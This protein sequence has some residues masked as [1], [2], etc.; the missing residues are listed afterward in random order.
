VIVALSICTIA[1][2]V[3][4]KKPSNYSQESQWKFGHEDKT[5]SPQIPE[6]FGMPSAT[7]IATPDIKG[8][9]GVLL[10]EAEPVINLDE[11]KI[12]F[13]SPSVISGLEIVGVFP[14]SAAAN[15]GLLVGDKILAVD[16]ELISKTTLHSL[17][18]QFSRQ[19]AARPIG[20]KICLHILRNQKMRKIFVPV[21]PRPKTEA[22]KKIHP[23]LRRDRAI[24]SESFLYRVLKD[25]NLL[26]DYYRTAWEIL[27]KATDVISY[28]IDSKKLNQFRLE[29][30][31]Y[32]LNNPMDLP[33]IAEKMVTSLENQ[34][35]HKYSSFSGLINEAMEGLDMD[36]FKIESKKGTVLTVSEI[37]DLMLKAL[38]EASKVRTEALSKLSANDI[39]KLYHSIS[40]VGLN[41]ISKNKLENLFELVH[42][43]DLPKLMKASLG[44]AR[45]LDD[46]VTKFP[47][48]L[49]EYKYS[50]RW[51]VEYTENLVRIHTPDGIIYLGGEGKNVYRE[52]ALIIIDLGGDDIYLNNAGASTEKYPYSVL[53]DFS[54]N[55]LYKSSTNV[56]QGSGFLGGGF[57]IDYDGNDRYIANTYSQ[58]S[59]FLGVGLLADLGGQDNYSCHSYCQASGIFGIGLL[60]EANGNDEYYADIFSQGVGLP[61]GFGALIEVAG[62]DNFYSGGVYPDHRQPL[63]AFKSMSQGF[64]YG[65]RPS[66][67]ET[68]ASGGIGIIADQ[69]G[70][71]AYIGDYFGQGS[72]YWYALGILSDNHGNDK[73]IAS[74]YSQGA[75]IHHSA[76]ILSDSNGDD[77]YYVDYGVSQGCGHDLAIGFLLDNGG[78]D[79]YRGGIIS[80]GAGN[81]NGFGVL[82]DNGGKDEYSFLEPGQ[83]SGHYLP[84]RNLGSLGVFIDTGGEED[85]YHEGK[86]NN[87]I[88]LKNRWG[89]FADTK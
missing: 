46:Q 43:V 13:K 7:K 55:D 88:I 84:F 73:Y 38:A 85:F 77:E 67:V 82:N 74:R 31:N 86:K 56:S 15:A 44:I 57:L 14:H 78:D 83:G 53:I 4:L 65:I 1:E 63:K 35:S 22:F 23:K 19:I 41:E 5:S 27:N 69:K 12:K 37:F 49:T 18:E 45:V 87:R 33:L 16:D 80:Q 39:E 30:V 17:R 11:I 21:L 28:S 54:G 2:A 60:A 24:N 34:F 81:G 52:D 72:S 68:G 6:L 64:G 36:F 75:G 58:G 61:K 51:K 50:S 42:K 29:E 48:S 89:I 8:W 10:K 79:K 76:G 9:L 62:D 20:Q 70:D 32:L 25:R 47:K 71:D 3:N 59:G 66:G 40:N 26:D